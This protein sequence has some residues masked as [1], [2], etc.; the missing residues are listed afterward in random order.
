MK[1]YLLTLAASALV[2]STYAAV[3]FPNDF[4]KE[5][6]PYVSVAQNLNGWTVYAP[7]ATPAGPYCEE[8][9]PNYSPQNAVQVLGGT[10]IGLWS[11]SQ[12][13]EGKESDTWIITPEIEVTSD[14]ELLSFTMEAIGMGSNVYNNFYVYISETGVAKEDFVL[15]QEG[16]FRGSSQGA[17]AIATSSKRYQLAG[18]AGKKIHLAFV[19][20]G[21]TVGMMSFGDIALGS[22]YAY[23]YPTPAYFDNIITEDGADFSFGMRVSTPVT[24]KSYTVDFRTSGGYTYNTTVN[25]SLRLN[26][27]TAVTVTIPSIKMNSDTETYTLSFTPDFEGAAPA[28]FTGKLVRAQR[29]FEAV[30]VMEEATGTWCGW[31]P[32]G[33]A[34]LAYYHNKYT[35]E[36]GTH[37]ALAIAI[38]G[39]DPMEI[40]ASISDYYRQFMTN[41]GNGGFPAVCVN[42]TGTITPSP[43]PT[44]TGN[45]LEK[46]FAAKSYATAQLT[47]VYYEPEISTAMEAKFTLNTTFDNPA[48]LLAVSAI[49][50]EDHVSGNSTNY[51]QSSYLSGQGYTQTWIIRNLGEDWGPYFE[52]Y[53]GK[54]QVNYRMIQ[55]DHVARGAFPS[56]AGQDI[57]AFNSSETYNG[58]IFFDMPKNVAVTENTNV[59]LIIRNVSTGEIV[60]ADELSFDEYTFASGVESVKEAADVVSTEYYTLD[61]R[62]VI[63]PDKGIVIRISH[64]SDGSI[65]KDKVVIR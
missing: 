1:K 41:E 2:M 12:Y 25:K 35:G 5:F 51:N 22:W 49:I 52:L 38:H 33:A 58:S 64:C 3:D 45:E 59:V 37:R 32:F 65:L 53:D 18:Y 62:R 15:F 29:N 7:D 63:N 28:V 23:G 26:S 47:G 9:F 56:Y 31:C 8:F 44:L 14:E 42:R 34:A 54:S 43:Y 57:P 21:N 19:N 61:G 20:Q 39:D 4:A 48:G 36:D 17:D 16:T 27:V 11:V 24:A 40:P 46:V 55:Y 6:D 60:A 13:T 50:T 10:I 30:G